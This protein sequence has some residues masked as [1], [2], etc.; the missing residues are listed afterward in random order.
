MNINLFFF[1]IF[2]ILFIG[3]NMKACTKFL[4]KFLLCIIITLVLL[5][6]MKANSNFKNKFYKQV[7]D[8][9][10]SFS[11]FTKIYNKYI[12]NTKIF[13]KLIDEKVFNEKPIIENSSKYLDGVKL[14][15]NSNYLVPVSESGV[16]VFIGE[17]EGYGNTIII[18]RIDGV[19][20]WYGNIDN[21]NVK[22]YD[23]VK[24]GERIG[25][26]KDYLYLVY[27]KDGEVLDYEKY[28]N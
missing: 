9:N 14:E 27:K 4:T 7:Y 6:I 2:F 8:K 25:E 13:D 16:V 15:F 21:T 28:I 11:Y 3:D 20:E 1:F 12:G 19:D 5:I 26:A 18:Q 22:M 10:I 17:K 23:Y 24:K